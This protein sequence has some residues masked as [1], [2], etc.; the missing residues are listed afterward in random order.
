M[1]ISS[2][3]YPINGRTEWDGKANLCI[4][5]LHRCVETFQSTQTTNSQNEIQQQKYIYNVNEELD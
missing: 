5:Q 3:N 2:K 1:K 4:P